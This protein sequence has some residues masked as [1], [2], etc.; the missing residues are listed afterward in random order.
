MTVELVRTRLPNP[1][2]ADDLL[3]PEMLVAESNHRIANNL[4]L[5]AGLVRMQASG[6]AKAGRPMTA[7]EV[8]LA[9]EEVGNRIETVGRLHRLL[10]QIGR[11]PSLDLSQ[12]LQD[13]AEAAVGS[14][15]SR[16]EI[17]L[18]H[19]STA[20][21]EIATHQALSLGFIVGELATNAMKYAHPTGISG[22]LTLGC[23]ARPG[24]A[25]LIEI[26][27][28]GVGLPEGFDPRRDGGLGMRMVRSLADQLRATLTFD[29][30]AIG[31]TVRLLVPPGG[32]D[33]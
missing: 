28:D 9:L 8:C 13:I 12:Y 29:S 18:V 26:I 31:L 32:A 24:G 10:A 20:D 6:I 2:P 3:G 11:R 25:T 4:T 19:A 14:M 33:G 16:G 17:R 7:D 5:I 1:T 22:C 23:H 27:D 15:S 21:C 30:S